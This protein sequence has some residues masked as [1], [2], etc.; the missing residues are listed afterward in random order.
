MISVFFKKNLQES[1]FPRSLTSPTHSKPLRRRA[2]VPLS[3]HTPPVLHTADR[4]RRRVQAPRAAA[5][6]S[7]CVAESE[8][9]RRGVIAPPVLL[10]T[11]P[12]CHR[13]PSPSAPCPYTAGSTR[14]RVPAPPAS[15]PTGTPRRPLRALLGPCVAGSEPHA[16]RIRRS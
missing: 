15:R 16:T 10:A 3:P 6:L 5:P 8:P 1:S 7:L 2:S 4:L 12:M 11:K 14:H 13:L 9:L